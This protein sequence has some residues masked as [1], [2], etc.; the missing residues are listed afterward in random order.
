MPNPPTPQTRQQTATSATKKPQKDPPDGTDMQTKEQAIDYLTAKDYLPPGSSPNL[1]TLAHILAQ[2]GSAANKMP[3]VL[4]DA[5]AAIAILIEDQAVSKTASEIVQEVKS[6]LQEYLDTFVG[7]VDTM[8]DAVE[9]VTSAAKEV[10]GKLNEFNDGFQVSAEHLAQATQDLVDK[11]AEN[12]TTQM[13]RGATNQ[14][15]SYANA[16]HQHQQQQQIPASH[17]YAIAKGNQAAKQFLIRKNPSATDNA[18]DSLTELEL[19]AKANTTIDLMDKTALEMPPDTVFVGAR[20]LR[21]GNVLYQLNS[22]N[23]GGWM[24]QPEVQKAFMDSYGGSS[25]IQSKLQYVIAEFVPTTFI[26]GST[27]THLKIEEHSGLAVDSIAYSKYIKPAQL[28]NKNQKVA[29]V[30]FGFN[31]RFTA[32]TAIQG[33]LFVEGKHVNIRKKLIEP[34]RCLKCQKFGH[35]VMDCKAACDSC[36]RCNKQHRTSECNVTDVSTFNCAN[37]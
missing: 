26:E 11:T 6:Q 21:N 25:H 27:F 22:Y 33:G 18:L 35:F 28:R 23:A 2:L 3:K 29:H 4:T 13:D 31:N 30:V 15:R 17:E 37:V 19:V 34:R 12:N 32:N 7:N 8:R 36:A 24:S 1:Q 14:P 10:T 5:I 9:H 16:I 20:K